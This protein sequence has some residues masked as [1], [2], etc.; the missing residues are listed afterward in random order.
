MA[1][2]SA[3]DGTRYNPGMV[4][5]TPAGLWCP[6]GGFHVDPWGPVERAVI[7]HAHGDHA[8]PGSAAYLCAA[9]CAG[10]AATPIRRRRPDRIGRVRP[11]PVA[12]RARASAFIPPATCSAPHRSA[13]NRPTASWVDLRRLQ[14]RAPI[15]PAR[16][17]SR[18]AATRS[19]PN[20]HS[21]CRF[22]A[23]TRP[24]AVIADIAGMV[25][26]ERGR[27][28]DLGALLLHARQGAA[29]ARGAVARHRSPRLRARA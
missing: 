1:Y 23:G 7:T 4:T 13:S 3:A 28:A 22:T 21:A 27:R 2:R 6:A 20:R 17:S 12:R 16:R 29:A 24:T 9:P 8:R 10:P 5:E 14:A 11:R 15:R 25:G 26:R 18:C 19:S